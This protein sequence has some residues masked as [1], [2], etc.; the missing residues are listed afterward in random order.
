MQSIKKVD[1]FGAAVL[2]VIAIGMLGISISKWAMAIGTLNGYPE[3]KYFQNSIEMLD[4]GHFFVDEHNKQRVYDLIFY[5]YY[6]LLLR[7]ISFVSYL[8]D[9]HLLIEMFSLFLSQSPEW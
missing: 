6:L 2:C 1:L 9:F 8:C 3:V 5:Y 4:L 7:G